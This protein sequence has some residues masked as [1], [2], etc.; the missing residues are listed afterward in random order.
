[1]TWRIAPSIARGSALLGPCSGRSDAIRMSG[2]PAPEATSP[3]TVLLSAP[4]VVSPATLTHPDP[5]PT[6][7][8]C[9]A[10][11]E[12]FA[13]TLFVRGSMRATVPST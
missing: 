8:A 13:V 7:S 4:S 12:A 9:G 6:A 10:P 5:A 11:T 3:Q 1:M 2:V